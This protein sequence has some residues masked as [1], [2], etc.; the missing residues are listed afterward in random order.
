MVQSFSDQL[1]LQLSD[2]LQNVERRQVREGLQGQDL[3]KGTP[4]GQAI[5]RRLQKVDLVAK[6]ESV[7]QLLHCFRKLIV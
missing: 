4:T 3:R 2:V 5:K 6:I 7:N 1:C